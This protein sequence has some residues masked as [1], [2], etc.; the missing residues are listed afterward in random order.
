[1]PPE[2]LSEFFA[3]LGEKPYRARQIM[4]WLYQRRV[5]DFAAMT[6]SP[7]LESVTC[8]SSRCSRR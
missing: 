3:S 7:M 6:A 5:L 1:M 8:R 4:R 2:A